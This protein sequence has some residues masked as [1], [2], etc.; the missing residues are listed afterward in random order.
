MIDRV[1]HQNVLQ[2]VVHSADATHQQDQHG[3]KDP[4]EQGQ[5]YNLEQFN[6][7]RIY[8]LTEEYGWLAANFAGFKISGSQERLGKKLTVW[9]ADGCL[10]RC[11][12]GSLN[13]VV[14]S[15][16]TIYVFSNYSLFF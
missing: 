14:G 15:R 7:A 9:A 8:T 3:E 2:I 6:S 12:F 1:T 5:A 16:S 10:D 13:H 11:S 4:I